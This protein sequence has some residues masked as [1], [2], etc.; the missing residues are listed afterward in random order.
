MPLSESGIDFDRFSKANKSGDRLISIGADVVLYIDPP[1][2]EVADS[3]LRAFDS[4]L[5]FC[6]KDQLHWYRTNTMTKHE[7]AT[8]RALGLLK[9]WLRAGARAR[10]SAALEFIDSENPVSTPDHLFGVAWFSR[11]SKYFEK[12]VNWLRIMFPAAILESAPDVTMTLVKELAD[13]TPFVSGHAGYCLERT[14]YYESASADAAYPLLMRHPGLDFSVAQLVGRTVLRRHI[15]GINWLTLLSPALAEKVGAR[16]LASAE[17]EG[18]SVVKTKHG[19][20]VKAGDRP[21]IGD[22][23]RRDR[24]PAYEAAYRLLKPLMAPSYG[25]FP[26][27]ANDAYDKTQRWYHRF[28]P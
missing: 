2:T 4:F 6:P 14:L 16:K 13:H 11:E 7:P 1:L 5:G 28:E 3:V 10:D 22:V 17:A 26:L 25:S 18:I 21:Q 12:R 27:S 8:P 20:I 9:T 19:V 15:K 24:V 23:N